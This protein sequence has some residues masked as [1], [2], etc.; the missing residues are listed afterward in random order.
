VFLIVRRERTIC[1]R[2]RGNNCDLSHHLDDAKLLRVAATQQLMQFKVATYETPANILPAWKGQRC[3]CAY[4]VLT[5]D[6]REVADVMCV[7]AGWATR[8][9]LLKFEVKGAHEVLP[10]REEAM[11]VAEAWF[12]ALDIEP[13]QYQRYRSVGSSL[14]RGI[15]PRNLVDGI[16]SA[17]NLRI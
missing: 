13:W 6:H 16:A 9:Y 11:R 2:K 17:K 15:S 3:G 12:L 5:L 4:D 14:A 10:T 8:N 7:P 1:L